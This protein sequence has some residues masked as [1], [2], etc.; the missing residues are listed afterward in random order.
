[1]HWPL[2]TLMSS[3]L[4]GIYY[5]R[6]EGNG[7]FNFILIHNAGGDHRFFHQQVDC[8]KK[9]GNVILL[10]LPGHGASRPSTNTS[11]ADSATRVEQLALSLSLDNICLVGL[12]NGGN[13]ALQIYCQQQ[14]TVKALILIDP[15]LF[16]DESFI[17]E[18][19]QFID[20]LETSQSETFIRQLVESLFIKTTDKN[21]QIAFDAFMR[22]DKPC[23]RAMFRSL[24]EWNDKAQLMIDAVNSPALC[25]LTDEHHC[26]YQTLKEHAP[27]FKLAK[28]VGSKCWATLEVPEQV[29]A[30]LIRFLSTT[31]IS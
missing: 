25:V 20:A 21:K 12:N 10:D 17:C 30:M 5:E 3:L 15:P 8:L 14:I 9:L 6:V 13:I 23:L 7:S 22:A 18:V 24:I 27:N 29:N 2:K 19:N 1:M 11:I 31:H 28:L 26:S 4:N 16:M